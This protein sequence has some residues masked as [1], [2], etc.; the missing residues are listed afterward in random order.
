M[1]PFTILILLVLMGAEV[2]HSKDSRS[3]LQFAGF[4]L[5]AIF[6]FGPVFLFI[7]K[8]ALIALPAAAK[9]MSINLGKYGASI[10]NSLSEWVGASVLPIIVYLIMRAFGF[11]FRGVFD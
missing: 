7:G 9:F 4:V 3:E 1:D 8:M 10:P 2:S 11:R 5:L 6:A